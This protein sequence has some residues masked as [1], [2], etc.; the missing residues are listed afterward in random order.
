MMNQQQQLDSYL[1][2]DGGGAVVVSRKQKQNKTNEIG[3][4][5]AKL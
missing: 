2:V 3:G 4:I 5:T 1:F